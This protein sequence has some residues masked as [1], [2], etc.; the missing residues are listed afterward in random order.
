VPFL[1]GVLSLYTHENFIAGIPKPL[2]L[3]TITGTY[4]DVETNDSTGVSHDENLSQLIIKL[5]PD[6]RNRRRTSWLLAARPV[7]RRAVTIAKLWKS[8]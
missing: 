4:S 7:W 2:S 6:C 3:G 8:F 5:D 1:H